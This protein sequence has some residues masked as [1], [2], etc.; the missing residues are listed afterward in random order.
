MTE[1]TF[2][3]AQ[4]LRQYRY[5]DADRRIEALSRLPEIISGS[6]SDDDFACGS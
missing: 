3:P 2:A 4:Q 6:R 5:R 1:L